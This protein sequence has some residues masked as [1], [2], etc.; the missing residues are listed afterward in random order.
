MS[1]D[2]GRVATG[3]RGVG[4][5]RGLAGLTLAVV[6]LLHAADPLPAGYQEAF[7]AITR[8]EHNEL[9]VGEIEGKVVAVLQI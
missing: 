9:I 3:R 6:W 5:W 4:R 2:R 7:D 1:G 8:D